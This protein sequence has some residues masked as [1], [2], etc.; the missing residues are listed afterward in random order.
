LT[1][2]AGGSGTGTLASNPGKAKLPASAT[3]YCGFGWYAACRS[4]VRC[5]TGVPTA[6]GIKSSNSSVGDHVPSIRL[7]GP[8][9][10][11]GGAVVPTVVWALGPG[12]CPKV[13][14]D[15]T[16]ERTGAAESDAYAGVLGC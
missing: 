4:G 15:E 11:A 1:R 6:G 12:F 14:E 13:V 16:L 3:G 8:S 2:T 10:E 5:I 9:D 7:G